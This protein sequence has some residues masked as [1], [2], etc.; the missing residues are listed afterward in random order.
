MILNSNESKKVMEELVKVYNND[1]D[2]NV[3][4]KRMQFK[5][6]VNDKIDK[7]FEEIKK[8]SFGCTQFKVYGYF[9]KDLS[10]YFCQ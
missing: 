4:N 6:G 5:P 2:E 3:L 7:F 10:N 8:L 1:L 9:I